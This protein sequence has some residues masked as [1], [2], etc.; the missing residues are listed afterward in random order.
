MLLEDVERIVRRN[1]NI[2]RKN[3][4]KVYYCTLPYN[5][6]IGE[7]KIADVD[8][9]HYLMTNT[10]TKIKVKSGNELTE[11]P[12]TTTQRQRLYKGDEQMPVINQRIRVECDGKT[13]T[14][15]FINKLSY[16]H[17]PDFVTTQLLYF[18]VTVLAVMP[19]HI[20]N[21][22]GGDVGVYGHTGTVVTPYYVFTEEFDYHYD[23]ADALAELIGVFDVYKRGLIT[24]IDSRAL[25]YFF[26][27]YISL[28]LYRDLQTTLYPAY[29][30]VSLE[31][32][33]DALSDKAKIILREYR[34][35]TL[36][37]LKGLTDSLKGKLIIY[38]T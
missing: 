26:Y 16:L 25:G 12:F 4:E 5:I 21:F 28:I 17:L 10:L 27:P 14:V 3:V 13:R 20:L 33:V 8:G 38:K 19:G 15:G 9:Y 36:E 7:I 34:N 32:V 30:N 37:K 1:L 6:H 2:I 29:V 22:S 35:D 23:K 18:K 11:V 24:K 31:E